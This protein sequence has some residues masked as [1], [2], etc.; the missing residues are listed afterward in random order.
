MIVMQI[1]KI[2]VCLGAGEW[3]WV[4]SRPAVDSTW[5]A[6]YD[7]SSYQRNSESWRLQLRYRAAG[8]HVQSRAVLYRR[9]S[10]AAYVGHIMAE[11]VVRICCD[12]T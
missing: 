5:A 11:H 9:R 3:V 8:N 10:P 1:V 7:N 2:A 6:A 4:L 12:T